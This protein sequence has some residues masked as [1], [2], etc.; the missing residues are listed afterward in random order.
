MARRK[1]LD[2]KANKLRKLRKSGQL[3]IGKLRIAN[4]GGLLKSEN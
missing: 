4:F 3:T 1:F 2:I